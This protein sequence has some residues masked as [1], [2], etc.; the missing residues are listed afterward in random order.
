M[1]K[2]LHTNGQYLLSIFKIILI[3]VCKQTVK[4]GVFDHE[5]QQKCTV[6][7]ETVCQNLFLNC[8]LANI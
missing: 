1:A 4:F 6:D 2:K 7:L 3:L 8:K 5:K